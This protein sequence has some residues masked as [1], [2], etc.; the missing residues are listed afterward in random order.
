MLNSKF[1]FLPKV[2]PI[3]PSE[4]RSETTAAVSPATKTGLDR[5]VTQE[6]QEFLMPPKLVRKNEP[7]KNSPVAGQKNNTPTRYEQWQQKKAAVP[8]KQIVVRNLDFHIEERELQA[9]LVFYGEI[10]DMQILKVRSRPPIAFVTFDNE[11][12]ARMAVEEMN[13]MHLNGRNLKL[14]LA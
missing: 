1:N 7:V 13:G 2:S 8:T 6:Q 14:A 3:Q 11:E 4:N 5:S 9:N 10:V 12:A